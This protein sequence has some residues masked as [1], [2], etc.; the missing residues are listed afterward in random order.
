[1]YYMLMLDCTYRHVNNTNIII[2]YNCNSIKRKVKLLEK[3]SIPRS[4]SYVLILRQYNN[5]IIDMK[6]LEQTDYFSMILS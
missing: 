5:H 6:Q 2:T 3:I 1:M 4:L